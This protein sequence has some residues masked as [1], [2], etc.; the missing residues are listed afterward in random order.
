MK[1]LEAQKLAAIPTNNMI[2]II[3]AARP[4]GIMN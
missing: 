3:F 1:F 2:D 4:M